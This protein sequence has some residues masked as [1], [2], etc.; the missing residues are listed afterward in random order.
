GLLVTNTVEGNTARL[1]AF[2]PKGT[3][4]WQQSAPVTEGFSDCAVPIYDSSSRIHY[5]G[6]RNKYRSSTARTVAATVYGLYDGYSGTASVRNTQGYPV[7]ASRLLFGV[8]KEDGN[9]WVGLGAQW[10]Y[11]ADSGFNSGPVHGMPE[12]TE[13]LGYAPAAGTAAPGAHADLC[14]G[15]NRILEYGVRS[16]GLLLLSTGANHQY[17]PAAAHTT[18]VVSVRET[19]ESRMDRLKIR[20]LPEDPAKGFSKKLAG[21][22]DPVALAREILDRPGDEAKTM[23]LTT[24]TP[25]G[26][27]SKPLQ[28]RP[29]TEYYYEYTTTAAEDIFSVTVETSVFQPASA[30][31]GGHYRVL[32]EY[33]ED[34]SG[35][36]P[37]SPFGLEESRFLNGWYNAAH[38]YLYQGSN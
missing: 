7:E 2:D 28:L 33:V 29:G 4:L 22:F 24:Q 8:E 6:I 36:R 25:E 38:A 23:I 37:G 3:L 10:T 26:S 18:H 12:R 21:P 9:V 1:R 31:E 16:P 19:R 15:L 32:A 17:Q 20:H 13:V 27:V 11:I 14:S 34:F 30:A 35:F 5:V